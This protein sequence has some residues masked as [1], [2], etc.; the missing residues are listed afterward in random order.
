MI[1]VIEVPIDVYLPSD[2]VSIVAMQPCIRFPVNPR[3]PF[4]WANDKVET[5]LQ[6]INRTLQIAQFGLDGHAVNFTLFPEYSI[7]GI[8][9]VNIINEK[10]ST[11]E[12]PCE[13]II[14][15]GIHGLSKSEYSEIYESLAAQ[16]RL[17]NEPAS[18][19]DNKWVNCCVVWVKE[20]DGVVK[21]WVQPKINPAWPE[22]NITHSHMFKGNSIYVF[23]GNYENTN[24]PCRFVTFVCFDWVASNAG[25]SLL[26]QFLDELDDTN[27]N[28]SID[29]DWVFVIQHNDDPNHD[30]F[31]T[32]T[33]MFFT[34]RSQYSFVQRDNA[35]VVHANTA[36]PL[37]SSNGRDGGFSACVFSPLAQVICDGCHPTV[38]TK[39]SILRKKTILNRCK[40][41]VFRE[42]REC[43]HAFTVR[44]PRFITPN[45]TG[46]TPPLPDAR[47]YALCET[48]DPRLCNGPVPADV[49]WIN[50]SLD[51]IVPLSRSA[52]TSLPLEDVANKIGFDT[53]GALRIP[54]DNKTASDII[55]W[56]TCIDTIEIKERQDNAD[57][58]EEPE[59][60]ALK[61]VVYSLTSIGIAYDMDISIALFHSL[62][63]GI[64]YNIHVIA[65]K[66]IS[67]ENCRKHYE[68]YIKNKVPV[69]DP[70]LV[71][72]LDDENYK[73][74]DDEFQKITESN[75]RDGISF[76]DYQRLI[77]NC[78]EANNPNTLKEKLDVFIPNG[79]RFI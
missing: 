15:A 53:I 6:A 16:I 21:K 46:R 60:K 68:E 74:T 48:S 56:A 78:R 57:L 75:K 50:D 22:N 7:P 35:V 70:I 63:K 28:S 30:S 17:G 24:Y 73:V 64:E 40:D 25:T 2:T 58:W 69:H 13:S 55:N 1:D 51:K 32:N 42:M 29:L 14:I 5:Q 62:I 79:C 72:T 41:V 52:F 23:R 43:V 37:L 4:Q 49:K 12:W 18:V 76:L 19:S 9:G 45:V 31:L 10:I 44:V 54:N 65:I 59:N 8:A 38:N 61:H 66:G 39:P 47:V 27:H 71:I 34:E 11:E 36:L 77:D 3:E 26:R 20:R 33:E 67:H